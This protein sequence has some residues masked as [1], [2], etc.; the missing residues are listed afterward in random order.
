MRK[1]DGTRLQRRTNSNDTLSYFR[2]TICSLYFLKKM[3]KPLHVEK[4]LQP[5]WDTTLHKIVIT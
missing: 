2:M 3:E 4:A 1:K 5:Y